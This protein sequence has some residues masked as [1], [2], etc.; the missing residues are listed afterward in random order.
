MQPEQETVPTSSDTPEV[1]TTGTPEVT[2][3]VVESSEVIVADAVAPAPAQVLDAVVN[4]AASATTDV[5]SVTASVATTEVSEV[6]GASKKA[7]LIA[8]AIL[9]GALCVAAGAYWYLNYG[10]GTPV[11]VGGVTYPAVVAVVNGE[12]VSVEQFK[13]SY[14]QAAAIAAQQGFDPATDESVRKEVETQA[15]TILVNTV[16]MK[17]EAA[18]GDFEATD[19]KVQEEVTKLEEQFGGAEQLATVLA[20]AGLDDAAMRKDLRDQIVVDAYLQSTPEVQAVV[21]TDEEVRAYYDAAAAQ[22]EEVPPYEEVEG[23][24][25]EQLLYEKQSAATS[26]VIDRVR[27]EATIEMKI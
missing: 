6:A 13:Q 20:G 27:A 23:Q 25:R 8:A 21:L 24:I 19:E 11:E 3:E 7:R 17:Q 5:A 4:E 9:V 18:K 14:D 16:L 1:P 15:L 10:T 12:K 22:M 26:A 2:P